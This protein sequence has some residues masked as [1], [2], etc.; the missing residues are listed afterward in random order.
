MTKRFTPDTAEVMQSLAKR[1]TSPFVTHLTLRQE[2]RLIALYA[3]DEDFHMTDL[4]RHMR[5]RKD[6][7][8][9]A[10]QAYGLQKR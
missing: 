10:L 6:T 9:A 8:I 3:T 7:V 2:I 4:R 5:V 1:R